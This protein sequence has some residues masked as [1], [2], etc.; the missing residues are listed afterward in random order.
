MDFVIQIRFK[1]TATS[2][3]ARTSAQDDSGARAARHEMWKQITEK[4]GMELIGLQWS[5]TFGLGILTLRGEMEKAVT[6]V[7][8]M[9]RSGGY[10]SI[11]QEV[12]VDLNSISNNMSNVRELEKI[13]ASPD[14]DEIDRILLED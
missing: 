12:I 7:Q 14:Q 10:E 9:T 8:M 11:E 6:L 1:L 13:F 3:R 2:M 4:L 5:I